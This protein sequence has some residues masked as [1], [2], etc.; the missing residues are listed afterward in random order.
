MNI[1]A[2]IARA[3]LRLKAPE[4]DPIRDHLAQ[5]H[6]EALEAMAAVDDEKQWRRLKGR[7]QLAKELLDLVES[8]DE[9]VTKLSRPQ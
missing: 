6:Q 8:S 9:L 4:F 3:Y 7:A 1:T 2:A 5:V